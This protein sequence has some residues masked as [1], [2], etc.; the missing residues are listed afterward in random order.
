M[1]R[2]LS[3]ELVLIHREPGIPDGGCMLAHQIVMLTTVVSQAP[4][5]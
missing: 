3:Q 1:Q 2:K 5:I 4:P